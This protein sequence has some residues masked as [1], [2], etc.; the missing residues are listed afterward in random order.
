LLFIVKSDLE[1]Q[2]H[3]CHVATTKY[4]PIRRVKQKMMNVT[5]LPPAILEI[6]LQYLPND[7]IRSASLVARAW[8]HVYKR[9]SC[10]TLRLDL[11]VN[12]LLGKTELL[13]RW[14]Q[15]DLLRHVHRITIADP[16]RRSQDGER[17]LLDL[18]DRWLSKLSGLKSVSWILSGKHKL[19]DAFRLATLPPKILLDL[20]CEGETSAQTIG[21]AFSVVQGCDNLRSLAVGFSIEDE[22]SLGSLLESVLLSC[23]SLTALKVNVFD[24]HDRSHPETS[25]GGDQSA[26]SRWTVEKVA[27][28]PALQ[29]LDLHCPALTAEMFELWTKNGDWSSLRTLAAHHS[30][31]LDNLAGRLPALES[32]SVST[33]ERL[34]AF[35]VL[36]PTLCKLALVNLMHSS[37]RRG[38][39]PELHDM[40]KLPF[41][42]KLKTLE[43]QMGLDDAEVEQSAVD[44]EVIADCC[45]E[46]QDLTVAITSQQYRNAV[47]YFCWMDACIEAVVRM[48]NLIRLCIILPRVIP[49]GSLSIPPE[50]ITLTDV[51]NIW[52]QLVTHGKKLQELRIT[53]SMASEKAESDKEAAIHRFLIPGPP[54]LT[55]VVTPAEKDWDAEKGAYTTAC[56]ELEQAETLLRG[57]HLFRLSETG[58]Y[59]TARRTVDD[60]STYVY[61]GTIAP[62]KKIR[63]MPVWLTPEEE[64]DRREGPPSQSRRAKRALIRGVSDFVGAWRPP[65]TETSPRTAAERAQSRENGMG[66]R[67][68]WSKSSLATRVFYRR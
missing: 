7:S 67:A 10:K 16:D 21:A 66:G 68:G 36:Q 64:Q 63:P 59:S 26:A 37:K 31:I 9:T 51:A 34:P 48:P 56:P 20:V 40:L 23:K 58:E 12:T 30:W 47:G 61:K 41:A 38:V 62:K 24:D 3:L 17:L 6:V 32:L 1:A 11:S 22:A 4:S 14:E 39:A 49:S 65:M 18:F 42:S 33:I 44:V 2:D 43:V 28:L 60:I 50:I 5:D 29:R 53:A 55:F 52:A 27:R 19:D 46:L 15:L 35:L 25:R 13:Q 54:S 57:G 45:P 8:S